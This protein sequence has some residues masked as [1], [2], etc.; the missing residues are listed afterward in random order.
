M[1]KT[2]KPIAKTQETH[3]ATTTKTRRWRRRQQLR[4]L[5]R[6]T[7]KRRRGQCQ[8]LRRQ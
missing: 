2:K 3:T 4:I 1:Q 5:Q 8:K 7:R 6:P